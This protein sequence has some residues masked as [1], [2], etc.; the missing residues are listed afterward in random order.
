MTL[1]IKFCKLI[2]KIT[3][4]IATEANRKIFPIAK[5]FVAQTAFVSLA[6]SFT[7]F[8]LISIDLDQSLA[9]AFRQ[10]LQMIGVICG[11]FLLSLAFHSHRQ[12]HFS[13]R[14]VAFFIAVDLSE[15]PTRPEI[16]AP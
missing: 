13:I 16:G 8:D 3:L 1:F 10:N 15:I 6:I 14:N 5:F 12:A 11:I 4:K 9:F 7:T 2:A